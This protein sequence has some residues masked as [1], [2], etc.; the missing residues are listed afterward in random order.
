[1]L[2]VSLLPPDCITTV[3]GKGSQQQR[4]GGLTKISQHE[5]PTI[6]TNIKVVSWVKNINNTNKLPRFMYCLKL[7]LNHIPLLVFFFMAQ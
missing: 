5:N 3:S 1:M 6:H 2:Q 7:Y 4:T